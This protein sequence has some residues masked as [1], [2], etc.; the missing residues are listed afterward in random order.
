MNT[1]KRQVLLF[2]S[3]FQSGILVNKDG[4]PFK[5]GAEFHAERH[6]EELTRQGWEVTV[7]TPRFCKSMPSKQITERGYR[8]QRLNSHFHKLH[9]AWLLLTDYR[10]AEIYHVVGEPAYTS[11]LVMIGKLLG[12]PLILEVTME[13]AIFAPLRW[14]ERILHPG[15]LLGLNLQRRCDRFIAISTRIASVMISQGISERKIVCIHQGIDTRRFLPA[16]SAEKQKIRQQL[17]LNTQGTIIIFCCRLDFRKGID[18]MLAAWE[19]ISRTDEQVRLLIVGGGKPE[20]V[21]KA[22]RAVQTS[23]GRIVYC[24]EVEDPLPYYQA[25]EIYAFP[26]RL[27][28]FPTS[29]MEAMASGCAPVVTEIGGNEDLVDEVLGTGLRC[30]PNNVGELAEKIILLLTNPE[31]RSKISYAAREFVAKNTNHSIQ[32]KKI[33]AEYE[34][35]L[36]SSKNR[37]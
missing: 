8:V 1:G 22:S 13:G 12:K 25:A 30:Q 24:G 19:K 20:W 17:K 18:L 9:L 11:I 29:L 4:S 14:S 16:N 23:N 2:T 27:E 35:L 37:I 26:S 31:H 36:A 21:E 5:S 32:V 15:R 7:V 3:A 6:A 28:G 34:L 10:Q 33:I